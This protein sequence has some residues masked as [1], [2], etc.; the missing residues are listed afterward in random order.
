M[1]LG[2]KDFCEVKLGLLQAMQT[3]YQPGVPVTSTIDFQV[4]TTLN[5]SLNAIEKGLLVLNKQ[6][7]RP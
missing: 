1:T 4:F 2:G 6:R 5:G 3:I 7:W